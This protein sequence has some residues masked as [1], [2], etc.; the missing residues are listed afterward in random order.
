[1]FRRFVRI[2]NLNEQFAT[3]LDKT[4]LNPEII[5]VLVQE[6]LVLRVNLKLKLKNMA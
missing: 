1:M 6:R 4:Y 5:S 2:L 3:V